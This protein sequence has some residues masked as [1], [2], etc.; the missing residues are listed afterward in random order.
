MV[1][2]LG[3]GFDLRWVRLLGWCDTCSKFKLRTAYWVALWLFG[4]F[5]PFCGFIGYFVG[6]CAWGC[7][8]RMLGL[9]GCLG[10]GL[11][12]CVLM[13]FGCLILYLV[14]FDCSLDWLRLYGFEFVL[15]CDNCC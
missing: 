6:N 10:S 15:C 13:L 8:F 7:C 2:D 5:E 11:F 3:F 14:L 9:G 4:N 12:G 1:L